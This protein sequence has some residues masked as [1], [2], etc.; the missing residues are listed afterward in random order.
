VLPLLPRHCERVTITISG[1]LVPHATLFIQRT[2]AG[3]AGVQEAAV[4]H[5]EQ[6][7]RHFDTNET[8]WSLVEKIRGTG[9][10]ERSLPSILSLWTSRKSTPQDCS[11]AKHRQLRLKAGVSLG[12]RHRRNALLSMPL[13]SMKEGGRCG[14]HERTRDGRSS[15]Y[16]IRLYAERSHGYMLSG[17]DTWFLFA[18]FIAHIVW[19][20]RRFSQ[21]M[22]RAAQDSR[23]EYAR[24]AG[25]GAEYST[26]LHNSRTG[27]FLAHGIAHW[28]STSKP[29]I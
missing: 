26:P 3:E 16:S 15:A 6:R 14:P 18:L 20:G 25:T 29:G 8:R 10:R 7:D 2:L 27:F 5:V 28:T 23:Y 4:N 1:R 9:R 22:S 12:G 11:S 17:R 19:A 21:G 24:C 13:M